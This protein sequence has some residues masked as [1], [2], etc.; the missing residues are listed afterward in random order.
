MSYYIPPTKKIKT[1][2]DFEERCFKLYDM[3]EPWFFLKGFQCFT[4]FEGNQIDK[5]CWYCVVKLN[6]DTH[7]VLTFQPGENIEHPFVVFSDW[8]KCDMGAGSRGFFTECEEY[9]DLACAFYD[10]VQG[11]SRYHIRYAKDLVMIGEKGKHKEAVF[12][13]WGLLEA[14]KI[15][16][17]DE[18]YK[19]K[20]MDIFKEGF[21]GEELLYRATIPNQ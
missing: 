17:T 6:E 10:M 14:I 21:T 12:G 5:K 13:D 16:H 11:Y 1:F 4:N 19:G 2:S 3:Y 20:T 7:T 8:A 15:I 18:K 9:D